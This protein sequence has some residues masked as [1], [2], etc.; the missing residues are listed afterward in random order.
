MDV[1]ALRIFVKVAELGSLTRA[2]DHLG[3]PKGQVS[4][5][6]RAPYQ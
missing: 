3:I 4:R 1:E 2:G 5:R 6:L